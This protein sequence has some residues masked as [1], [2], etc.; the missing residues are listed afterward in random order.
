MT[1]QTQDETNAEFEKL[2]ARPRHYHS[3]SEERQWET[4]KDLGILDVWLDQKNLTPEMK[5]RYKAYFQ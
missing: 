1:T 4:D 3:M 5:A 2:F